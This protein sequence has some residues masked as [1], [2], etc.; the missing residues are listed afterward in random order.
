V[1]ADVILQKADPNVTYTVYLALTPMVPAV[2]GPQPPL[3]SSSPVA[4]VK[5]TTT[6]SGAL[7]PGDSGAFV[8]LNP[9]AHSDQIFSATYVFPS[10]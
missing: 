3:L 10:R 7:K 1:S 9:V 4:R 2:R 6:V 8:W 5:P